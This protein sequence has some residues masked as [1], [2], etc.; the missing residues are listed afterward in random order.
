MKCQL[1][2]GENINNPPGYIY[3]LVKEGFNAPEG[4]ESA[5]A[6]EK[7]QTKRKTLEKIGHKVKE[8]FE[9]GIISSFS[10]QEDLKYPI[11][12]IPN[13]IMFIYK[14]NGLPITERFADWPSEEY[15]C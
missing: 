4:F 13:N 11:S 10:P 6:A 8:E 5:E 3:Q 7:K 9:A 2:K 12:M 1:K 14:K 15:F